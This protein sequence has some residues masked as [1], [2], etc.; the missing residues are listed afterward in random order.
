METNT[1]P[2]ESTKRA[3]RKTGKKAKAPAKSAKRTDGLIPLKS[4]CSALRVEPKLA[5]RKLRAA[6]LS[7]HTLTERWVMTEAQAA[8]VRLVIKGEKA[9]KKSKAAK[10]AAEAP[11]VTEA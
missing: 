1:T 10:P 7:F 9:E 6:K 8:K 5:R 3:P 4:I 11:E 2:A